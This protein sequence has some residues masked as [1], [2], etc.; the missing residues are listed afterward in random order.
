MF[1]RYDFRKINNKDTLYLYLSSSTEEAN[2]FKNEN[3]ENIENKIKRFIKQNN[4]DYEEGPVYVI[5]NGI[6]IKSI[7]IKNKNVELKEIKKKK[8]NIY[9]NN[10]FI[11]NIRFSN[12]KVKSMTLKDYLISAILTNISYDCDKELLKSIIVL[13]R[14]YIYEK[15]GKDGFVN[16]ND[17]FIKYKSI[18]YFKLLWFYNFNELIKKIETC[19]NETDTTFITY[20]NLYIKPYIHNTNNGTTDSLPSTSYLQKV[21]SLWDLAS[22]LYLSITKYKT[23]EVLEI[24]SISKEELNNL[25]ILELTE[26]GCIDK[27]KLGKKVFTGDSFM[28]KL[29][30]PSKD[31]TILID[32]EIVTFINRG[33]GNNLG[34]SLEG[35]KTLSKS[36]CNY[37]QILNYYF[38][39]CKIKKYI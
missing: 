30:L 23:N 31:M 32:E 17:E 27:I 34:L 12:S 7:D 33:Y 37:L 11:V 10:E 38:P 26:A 22:P 16:N 6:I 13:Y 9:S 3:N 2:E 5:S 29:H 36:G 8:T 21:N 39:K 14:T 25:K 19:I 20:N 4:I 1:Y 24:L 35:G 28:N 15:M 18:S